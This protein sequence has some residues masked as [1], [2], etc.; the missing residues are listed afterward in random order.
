M[1]TFVEVPVHEDAPQ[2]M[3]TRLLECVAGYPAFEIGDDRLPV[4]GLG[5]AK[6]RD[7]CLVNT[8]ITPDALRKIRPNRTDTNQAADIM[9]QYSAY[10]EVARTMLS[11]LDVQLLKLDDG[12]VEGVGAP[13]MSAAID[14]MRQ[15]I[16]DTL[17]AL[18][19]KCGADY[20][21]EEEKD[22]TRSES[23]V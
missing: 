14:T 9:E 7:G 16:A 15:D 3:L 19:P 13:A 4:Q 23:P 2:N 12:H 8:T 17:K 22:D 21:D 6:T 20:M 11:R 18:A 1:T 5:V 10:L